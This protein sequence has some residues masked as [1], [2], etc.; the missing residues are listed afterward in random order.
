VMLKITA[1]GPKVEIGFTGVITLINCKHAMKRKYLF[2]ARENCSIKFFGT[3][4]HHV[5]FVFVSVLSGK[6]AFL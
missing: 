6:L 4:L 1:R 5:Y 3:K 2:I